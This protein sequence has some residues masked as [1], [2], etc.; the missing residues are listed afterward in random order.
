MKFF[1]QQHTANFTYDP[2]G[3]SSIV[4]FG[5]HD[6]TKS[7]P[8]PVV[9][10]S[11]LQACTIA[12]W[13]EGQYTWFIPPP[14]VVYPLT[15]EWKLWLGVGCVVDDAPVVGLTHLKDE[16]DFNN[17]EGKLFQVN[18]EVA[19]TG[20]LTARIVGDTTGQLNL[21]LR[22]YFWPLSGR[23]ENTVGTAIG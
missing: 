12:I 10:L 17:R 9:K 22:T 11:S 18:C 4:H 6:V 21:G 19:R 1:N 5:T 7:Q 3:V 8:V 15:I 13:M 20:W 2:E 16:S 23:P 14:S